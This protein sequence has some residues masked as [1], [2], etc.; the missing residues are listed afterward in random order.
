MVREPRNS[1]KRTTKLGLAISGLVCG[2]LLSGTAE[3]Q[4]I[5]VNKDNRTIAITAT[6]KASADADTAV[7]HIGF[8]VFAPDSA[9]AYAKGSQISN[10]V[11]AA[12]TKAGVSAKMI[13][14]ENQS[15]H[16]NNFFNDKDT[17]QE[18]ARK[19]FALEQTWTVDTSAKYAADV[20]HTAVQAGANNSGSID[21]EVTDRKA[22]Q[23]EAAANALSKGQAIA[24]Q[25]AKGLGV[26]LIGLIY[27]SNQAPETGVRPVAFE[28]MAKLERAPAAQPLAIKPGKIEENATVYAV[29]AIE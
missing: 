6:D 26:K 15:L 14:S 16:P 3:A 2:L 19:Q 1:E 22:L 23:A 9:T 24:A 10:A 11:V 25:M 27:A 12:L 28:T 18:R 4:Q 17:E 7:V 8:Q 5:Q 21:W 29:F 13:R 20:L